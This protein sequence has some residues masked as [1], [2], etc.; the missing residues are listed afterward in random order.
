MGKWGKITFCTLFLVFGGV[1]QTIAQ[2]GQEEP[3]R[4]SIGVMGAVTTGHLDL[5][6]AFQSSVDANFE[7]QE[8]LNNT[9]GFNI[10]YV[11]TPEIALQTNVVFGKFSF[12]SDIFPDDALTF[13]NNYVTTSLTTQ[14]SLVRIF[15]ASAENFNL[16]GSF[17]TGLMFNDV[18][19]DSE[20]PEIMN[21]D[22]T[23][24]DHPFSNFFTTF[25]GGIRF[26]LGNRIDSYAQYEY[27]SASRDIIDGNFI[28]ELLNLGGSS[29]ISNSWSAV[30]FGVQFKFGASNIDADW[31]TASR[32][33]APEP[34][35]ERDMFERLEEL[36]ARQADMF[37]EEINE[38]TGRIDS[39]ELALLEEKQRNDQLAEQLE[40]EEE[41]QTPQNEEMAEQIRE[42]QQQVAQLESAL[43]SERT[44][45]EEQPTIAEQQDEPVDAA[46]REQMPRTKAIQRVR[47]Q[48]EMLGVK[49]LP[50]PLPVEIVLVPDAPEED[51]EFSILAEIIKEA[52]PNLEDIVIEPEPKEL[53][54]IAEEL[55]ANQGQS[56]EEETIEPKPITDTVF[57]AAP[58]TDTADETLADAS[59]DQEQEE[60]FQKADSLRVIESIEELD[61]TSQ[62]MAHV[63]DDVTRPDTA[64]LEVPKPEEKEPEL[65]QEDQEQPAPEQEQDEPSSES[66]ASADVESEQTDTPSDVDESIAQAD[67]DTTD[68]QQGQ[69]QEDATQSMDAT[70]QPEDEGMSWTWY[71]LIAVAVLGAVYFVANMFK[72]KS[73]SDSE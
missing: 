70:D 61:S 12:L 9:L 13:N 18:S 36:L 33:I 4:L 25:G 57:E 17:G 67:T 11:A 46:E 48:G 14:L 50:N 65:P 16:F 2:S 24:A 22:V 54:E 68:M 3:N 40:A 37:Q 35:P 8:R 34:P 7:F 6:S 27:S 69:M 73:G 58:E 62:G 63:R 59:L 44:E 47:V 30:T 71:A 49:R 52:Q 60:I 15:G 64:D 1:C 42:L 21:S 23:P 51:D 43:A 38:L 56:L 66:A 20:A 28:G 41:E 19:I 32:V 39:L 45:E 53:D 72:P 29:E 10:R 31:P 26:N 55:Q 5:G